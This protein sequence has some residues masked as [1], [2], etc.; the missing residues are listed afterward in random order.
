MRD[1]F[2]TWLHQR[3]K[4]EMIEEDREKIKLS[5][6]TIMANATQVYRGTIPKSK[7]EMYKKTLKR[8]IKKLTQ[9]VDTD[10]IKN[11]DIR[12]AINDLS[13]IAKIS[14]GASQKVINVYLKFYCVLGN[15]SDSIINEL[16]CPVDSFVIKEN[17]LKKV[18]LSK[19]NL[20]DYELMQNTLEKRYKTRLLADVISWDDKKGY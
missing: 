2:T 12:N 16:D 1:E 3:S 18:P 19:L 15:K 5:F 8:L 17:K 10:S 20:E 14:V 13:R 7:K 4:I 11:N 6:L 9:K